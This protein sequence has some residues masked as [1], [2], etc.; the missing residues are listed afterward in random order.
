MTI[1]ATLRGEVFIIFVV[2]AVA[3]SIE[4]PCVR[5]AIPIIVNIQLLR[6]VASKSDGEKLLPSP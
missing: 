1:S 3:P 4:K 2:L 6:D 5:A